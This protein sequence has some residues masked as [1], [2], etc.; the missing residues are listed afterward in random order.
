MNDDAGSVHTQDMVQEA[1]VEYYR[2]AVLPDIDVH[3]RPIHPPPPQKKQNSDDGLFWPVSTIATTTFGT[4][5]Y[6]EH[7]YRMSDQRVQERGERE[8]MHQVLYKAKRRLQQVNSKK[9]KNIK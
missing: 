5:L 7:N 6:R 1:D 4:L 9:H 3:G 2:D 8:Y